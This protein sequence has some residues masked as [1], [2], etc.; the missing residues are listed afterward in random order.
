MLD[1]HDPRLLRMEYHAQLFQDPESRG[2]RR[3]RLRHG[4]AG[5]HPVVRDTS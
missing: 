1:M 3:S 2:H 5:N 4:L